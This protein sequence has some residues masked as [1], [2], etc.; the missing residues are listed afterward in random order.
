M[1]FI[2]PVTM[3]IGRVHHIVC[4]DASSRKGPPPHTHWF[5]RYESDHENGCHGKKN[6]TVHGFE[7]KSSMFTSSHQHDVVLL[8]NFVTWCEAKTKVALEM[9]VGYRQ[10]LIMFMLKTVNL[11]CNFVL[12]VALFFVWSSVL[13]WL[14]LCLIIFCLCV[15]TSTP[16][17]L[18]KL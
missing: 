4:I 15:C 9:V 8:Y 16:H 6:F 11:Y 2:I 17:C 7:R 10:R 13:G 3:V 12:F 1:Q 18:N 14:Y 5:T